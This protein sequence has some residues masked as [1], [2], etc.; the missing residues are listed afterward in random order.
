MPFLW[1]LFHPDSTNVEQRVFSEIVPALQRG[2][3]D[4]GVCIHEARFTWQQHGLTLVE[5]LGATWERTSGLP[6]PLGGL[7]AK[8]ALSDEALSHVTDLV[9]A[10]LDWS[11][12]HPAKALEIMRAHAQEEDECSS[13]EMPQVFLNLVS[14]DDRDP[15]TVR[16]T[17]LM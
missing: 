6:L 3:A 8:S 7:L 15:L 2:E 14:A 5:D 11:R 1:R 9:R 17:P 10:S 12:T 16:V 4:A 13:S